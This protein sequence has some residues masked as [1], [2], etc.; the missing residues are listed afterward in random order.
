MASA[1]PVRKR[2]STKTTNPPKTRVKPKD[3]LLYGAQDFSVNPEKFVSIPNIYY[4][5]ALEKFG[6]TFDG[7]RV[8]D[9][10]CGD[11]LAAA[12]ICHHFAPALV[13]GVDINHDYIRTQEAIAG[14][15]L[16]VKHTGLLE[17]STIEPFSS[18]GEAE[19][20]VAVSWSV[21]EHVSRARFAE[22]LDILCRALRPGAY[23]VFQVAPLFYSAMGHHLFGI[24]PPWGHLFMMESEVRECIERSA[25]SDDHKTGLW[26]MYS[27]LNKM[28]REDFAKGFA[29]AG[30]SIEN[31]YVTRNTDTPP[32]RLL[33][34]YQ[35]DCIMTEQVVWTLKKD[36]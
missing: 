9:F 10:G 1:R 26:G 31:E 19:Y 36:I 22:Q 12:G 21:L 18:L 2:P 5:A 28:T 25:A 33:S 8:L 32:E 27:T 30:F 15:K 20:D 13:H 14:G 7:A 17:L 23:C 3:G 4:R 11:G 34:I 16:D 35:E 24:L 6:R 29:E